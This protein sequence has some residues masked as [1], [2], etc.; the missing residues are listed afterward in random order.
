VIRALGPVANLRFFTVR[1]IP[2]ARGWTASE[3]QV[4]NVEW[5]QGRCVF[6]IGNAGPG[7]FV[8][9]LSAG[10]RAIYERTDGKCP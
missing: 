3:P 6:V 1:G 9:P 4:G 5:V 7:P 2:G 8:G 10:V